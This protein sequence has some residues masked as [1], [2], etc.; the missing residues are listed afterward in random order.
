VSTAAKVYFI[1]LVVAWFGPL[2]V[3]MGFFDW[4]FE[5]AGGAVN[6]TMAVWM[7]ANFAYVAMWDSR[8]R[9]PNTPLHQR[10]TKMVGFQR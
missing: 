7:V 10:M 3:L 5:S 2:I 4:S 1:G 8:K 9:W 6:I